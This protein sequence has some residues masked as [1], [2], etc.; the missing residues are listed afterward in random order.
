MKSRTIVTLSALALFLLFMIWDIRSPN[1]HSAAKNPGKASS[2][3]PAPV[4]QGSQSPYPV[5]SA[6]HGSYVSTDVRSDVEP[7]LYKRAAEAASSGAPLQANAGLTIHA[8]FDGTVS[9]APNALAI[10]AMITNAV[11]IYQSLYSDPITVNIL[12]R[13]SPNEVNGMP[14][15]N[16]TLARSNFVIYTVAWN[17]YINALKADA[18]T[19][20]D[21]TANASLPNS[22]LTTHIIPSSADGRAIGLSTP[23]TMCGDGTFCGNGTYDGIVT[24]NS[25]QPFQFTRPPNS[26]NYD[27]LRSTEHEMDEVLGLGSFISQ[28]SDLRPQDLFSWS[29]AGTRNTTSSGTRYFSIDGGTTNIVGFNQDSNGDFG[30]WFSEAC[31]Q[32]HPYVQNAFSCVNQVSDVTTT[33]PEGINLDVIGYDLVGTNTQMQFSASNYPVNESVAS[34][35]PGGVTITVNRTGDTSG[36][37][38]VDFKTGNNDYAPCNQFDGQARQNCKFIRTEGTLTFNPGDASKSFI[39][40]LIDEAYVEGTT[41]FPITLSNPSGGSLGSPSSATVTI[42]DDDTAQTVT[43]AQFRFGA[44]FTG[45]QEIPPTNSNGKG[46]GYVLLSQSQTSEQASLQWSNLTSAQ[47]VQHIHGPAP[48]GMAAGVIF[49]FN[50][51]T[52]VINQMFSPTALQVSDLKAGLHYMNVHT[53]NFP[54]GEIRGQLLWNPILE[55][56]FFVLEHY[57]DFLQRDPRVN[58]MAGFNFWVGQI[59]TCVSDAV[60]FHNNT[61]SVSN[62]YFAGLEYQQTGAYVYRLLRAAFGNSQP[63]PNPGSPIYPCYDVYASLRAPLVGSSNL[64]ADLQTAANGFVNRS[65]FMTKYPS[66]LMLPQF[67][68]AVLMTIQNDIGVNLNSQR[69]ALIGLASRG[70]VMYRLANDDLGGLNGGINNQMFIDAEYNRSFVVTQYFGYLRRD[71]D[72]GGITFWLAQVNSAPLRDPSK[73]QAMV[74]SFLTSIEYQARF[75]PI[76]PRTNAEC[77]Q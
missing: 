38:T 51:G 41:T 39:V 59:S 33:S 55:D 48:P 17:D 70:A 14:L 53:T 36:T 24:L 69:N 74:C 71:G 46:T 45:G 47:T 20:N 67:V 43:P 21:T 31:P 65:D 4:Q 30:D 44:A 58:D 54:G 62:Q 29:S 16:G 5:G 32:A 64:A 11:N 60:C 12:F 1:A 63:C 57:F 22:A 23:G 50:N 76:A 72:I 28:F 26:G 19:S 75:G 3:Q 40:L 42:T 37:S 6:Q 68:D 18:T 35:A 8:F 10:E 49:P 66:G 13:Y 52:P 2:Q 77:P 27:A 56:A 9:S 25:S 73:Q 61:I 7:E 15:P 34:A